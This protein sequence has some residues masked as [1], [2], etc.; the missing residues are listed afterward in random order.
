MKFDKLAKNQ[1]LRAL[2]AI[3]AA[4]AG[5]PA[6][7]LAQTTTQAPGWGQMFTNLGQLSDNAQ[8]FIMVAAALVG[9]FALIYAGILIKKKGNPDTARDVK[10]SH[11]S[12]ALVAGIF[13]LSIS[14]V[15]RNSVTTVGGSSSDVGRRTVYNGS[16]F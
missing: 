5:T 12:M 11:I 14:L 15:V 16:G 8:A 6:T 9:V 3:T 7:V 13:M 10:V 1:R 2:L 4:C